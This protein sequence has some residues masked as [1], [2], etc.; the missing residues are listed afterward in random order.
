MT[1]TESI[2]RI[3]SMDT[4]RGIASFF[5]APAHYSHWYLRIFPSPSWM[6]YLFRIII[7]VPF[8]YVFVTLPGMAVTLQLFI[9]RKKGFDESKLRSSIIKRGLIL[10]IIQYICNFLSYGPDYTW[11]WFILSFIGLS[12]ILSYFLTGSSEKLRIFLIIIIIILS[13]ILKYLFFYIYLSGAF[14]IDAWS[15]EFF[16]NKMLFEVNFPIFPYLVLPIFGTLFAEKMIKAIEEEKQ[17]KFIKNSLIIGGIL[18]LFYIITLNFDWIFNF[19]H[20]AYYSLPT[21]QEVLFSFGIVMIIIALFFWIQDV[22]G[23]DGKIF[24]MFEVFSAISLTVFVTHFYILPP[25]LELIYDPAQN[26]SEYS[27]FQICS[28]WWAIYWICGVIWQRNQR[29]YSLEWL[30]RRLS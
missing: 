1:N 9:S 6:Q 30:L 24:R 10:I 20:I 13:P 29:K 14:L 27:V 8:Q 17:K 22:N 21:R 25:I 26:L 4:A 5:L 11:N 16:L 19:P 12:I 18:V 23:K 15:I 7:G 3:K 28:F 2:K